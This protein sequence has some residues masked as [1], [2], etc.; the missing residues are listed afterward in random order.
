MLNTSI[1]KFLMTAGIFVA[2]QP[3]PKDK[4]RKTE[5]TTRIRTFLIDLDEAPPK[6]AVLKPEKQPARG[7]GEI[8]LPESLQKK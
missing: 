2:I 7:G 3:H 8:E 1:F 5:F 6:L 4:P